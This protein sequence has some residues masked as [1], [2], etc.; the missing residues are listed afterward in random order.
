MRQ[1]PDRR[2][3]AAESVSRWRR[4]PPSR[5]MRPSHAVRAVRPQFPRASRPCASLETRARRR[6]HP[7]A[8]AA[9]RTPI[10]PRRRTGLTVTSVIPASPAASSRNTHSGMLL[11]H[12]ATR[13]PG[14]NR[15]SRARAARSD[16]SS[17]SAYVHRRLSAAS[18][19]PVT[20]ATASGARAAVSRSNPPMVSSRIGTESSA[21]HCAVE[22]SGDESDMSMPPS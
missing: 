3:A 4:T 7:I 18:G 21:V 15:P 5:R 2:R 19:M 12:T 16:S 9:A 11:A 17:S 22:S 10:P 1:H 14:A 20:S 8:T 13:S 6:C